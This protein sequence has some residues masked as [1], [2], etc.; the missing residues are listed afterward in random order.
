MIII[1]F[2]GS[3]LQSDISSINPF[4]YQFIDFISGFKDEK[5]LIVNGGG[6]FCRFLQGELKKSGITDSVILDNL[7]IKIN[8][9]F[10]EFIK[11]LLPQGRTCPK[12]IFDRSDVKDILRSSLHYDFFVGGAKGVGHSSDYDAVVLAKAFNETTILKVSNVGNVYDK[13]PKVFVDASPIESITWREYLR[14]IDKTFMPGGN[15]PFDPVASRL[16]SRWKFVVKMCSIQEI[17]SQKSFDTSKLSG[18]IIHP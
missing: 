10:S 4:F 7:G 12:L 16:A 8:N 18:T 2:G 9:V 15:Y 13:D 6:V 14:I 5:F 11:S 1:K 17:I 3:V